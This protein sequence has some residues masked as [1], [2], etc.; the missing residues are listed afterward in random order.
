LS[1]ALTACKSDDD[2]NTRQSL[3]I[4][5]THDWDNTPVTNANF[6]TIQYTNAN[7]DELSIERLRYLISDITFHKADGTFKIVK[8]HILVDVSDNETLNNKLFFDLSQSLPLPVGEYTNV[9]FTFGFDNNDNY[10]NYIDL[11]SA[12]FNVPE[13]LGGGYHFM[14]FD[15]KFI[16]SASEEQGFNYHA[17]RAV[18]NS[19]PQNLVFEDTFFNVD[20]GPVTVTNNTT[21]EIKMNIAEWFKN[22][23]NWD[24]NQLNQMLMPNFNAQVIMN[25]NGQN[26]FSLGDVTQQ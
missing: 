3:T 6:N 22:P 1:I 14:Q 26:V 17:I 8:G 25:Q 10:E 20:L 7:G 9:S 18:D 13:M 2:A 16:N 19:D 23:I 24:L 21:M 15:G 12:S 4:S 11:N 5:F